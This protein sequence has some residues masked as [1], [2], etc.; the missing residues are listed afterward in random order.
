MRSSNNLILSALFLMVL[1]FIND[2]GLANGAGGEIRMQRST[3]YKG[4]ICIP[5][6]CKSA[7][8]A[9]HFVDG[10]CAGKLLSCKKRHCFCSTI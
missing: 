5:A 8:K 9:E 6:K 1:L 3:T 7:C 4:F 2:I 10:F